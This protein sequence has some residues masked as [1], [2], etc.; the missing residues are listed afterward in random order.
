MRTFLNWG[1]AGCFFSWLAAAIYFFLYVRDQTQSTNLILAIVFFILG[2]TNFARRRRASGGDPRS[3]PKP[4]N[5]VC[6]N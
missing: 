6:C 1:W 3:R 4:A 5:T 2:L